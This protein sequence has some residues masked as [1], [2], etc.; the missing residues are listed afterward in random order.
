MTDLDIIKQIEKELNIKLIKLKELLGSKGYI[1]N[2][3]KQITILSFYNHSIKNL[4][5]IKSQLK[6]LKQLN[7]LVLTLNEIKDCSCLKELKQLKSLD[8]GYNQIRNVSFLKELKQLQSLDLGSNQISDY[9]F[10]KELKQLQSLDLG[11]NQ[12]SDYSFLKELKQLQS[13]DLRSNQIGDYSFLKELTQLQLLNLDSNQISDYSFLKE[14][15]QLQSLNLSSNQISDYSFLKELK[16]LK[17]LI[18]RDNQI[19]NISFL[20]ELKQLKSL[21]LSANKISDYSFLKELKQLQSLDLSA[22]KISDYSFLKE[23]KQLQSLDLNNTQISDYSFLKELKQLQRLNLVGNKIR[24][25]SFLKGLNLLKSLNLSSNQISNI[26]SIRFLNELQ[27]L[28]L[29]HNR[30]KDISH[31]KDLKKLQRL[32]LVNNNISDISALKQLKNLDLVG[33]NGNKISNLPAWI[34]EYDMEIDCESGIHSYG[35]ITLL[36][37]PLALPPIEIVK[38][39]KKAIKDYF[40]SL[41]GKERVKLNEVKVL[42]VGEGMSGKTSLLKQFQGLPFDKD[43]S[44]THGINVASFPTKNIQGLTENEELENYH[45]HFWDFGGQEIMHASHQFFL[46]KRS[47]YILVLDSRTDSKKYHWLKHIEKFGGDS[48]LII[49]MNKIDANPNY[50]IEQKRINESFPLIKNRFHRISCQTQEGFGE[51]VKCLAK[52]IP[53]TSLF[54]TEISI[55]WMNIKEKLVT[56]TKANRYIN[57]EMFVQICKN[58]NVSDQSSQQTLLQ[59]LNDLGIVLYF[60]QLNLANI[61]VLDPHWVTIGVYKIINSQRTKTGILYEQDLDFILN[62]E[63]IKK[64]EYDPA[65]EKKIIYSPEEQYYI[66]SI[67]K[68]FELCYE[69]DRN[70]NYCIIPDLLPKELQYE[71]ELNNGILLHFVIIY[72]YLPSTILPRLMI[73]LKND[74]VNGQQW[75]YGM[76]LDNKEFC[77]KAKIK[78]DESNKRI[79]IIIQGKFLSKQKYF[80]AIRFNIYDINKEF[81]NL[82]IQEFIPLPG[83]PELLIEYKELLGYEQ[84]G[85]DE[86]FVGKLGK[87]FSVSEML[88]SVINKQER[89]KEMGDK[90]NINLSN[91]GNSQQTVSQQVD[92]N[93][94]QKQTVSQEVK[95]VQALFKNLKEDILTEIDIEIEDEKEKKRINKELENTEKAFLEL[96]KAVSEDKK[97]LPESTKN[98]IGEFIDNLSD[99]NSRFNKALKLVS[100]GAEKVQKLGRI[101]NNIAPFFVLPSIPPSLLGKKD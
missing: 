47:L 23:L 99:E 34:V 50:N 38:Q 58:N 68:N 6:E 19:R 73:R 43:E 40:K 7:T 45:I 12:I 63:E 84:A 80:S 29:A 49:V 93:V 51:L 98:R 81:E 36:E 85:R 8:L 42:L 78:E 35:F 55:D 44:Q 4:N 31:L 2:Q 30:I 27:V 61:Y 79:D 39:G 82:V 18:L 75:K 60:K 72:D 1:I 69:Y 57:R 21:D 56:E 54:G 10:L 76:I 11:S 28:W 88:D 13:L 37:N 71:P 16:Q 5:C 66:L 77:C 53:E 26:S 89:A 14:L 41:E 24:D 65:K 64:H 94:S 62:K 87:S 86:Y 3:H 9:S 67:M 97:E 83:Y 101:Y 48:P 59:Y 32:Q 74:I 95:T 22:N 96:E 91:I 90:I 70:K 25:I 17:S 33:L 46:S 15:T 100:K 20:K 52:T 92:Q